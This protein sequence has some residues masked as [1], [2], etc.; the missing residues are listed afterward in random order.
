MTFIENGEAVVDPVWTAVEYYLH[1]GVHEEHGALFTWCVGQE[2]Y[3]RA[4][5]SL[6]DGVGLRMNMPAR[7]W[8]V[9]PALVF[10]ALWAAVEADCDL[11]VAGVKQDAANLE[12]ATR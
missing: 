12:A 11:F 4:S 3:F 2:T 10:T 7:S 5:P 8:R 9:P 6:R 1:V